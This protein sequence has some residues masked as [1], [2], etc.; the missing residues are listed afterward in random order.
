MFRSVFFNICAFFI[1]FSHNSAF[2]CIFGITFSALLLI[3]LSCFDVI[4][5]NLSVLHYFFTLFCFLAYLD[6]LFRH[7]YRFFSFLWSFDFHFSKFVLFLNFSKLF[8]LFGLFLFTFSKILIIC[9]LFYH[10]LTYILQNV[11]MFHLF[12][13]AFVLGF[14][15]IFWPISLKNVGFFHSFPHLSAFS[16]YLD[17]FFSI[18]NHFCFIL[19]CSH[20]FIPFST[21]MNLP[22]FSAF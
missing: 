3:F 11:S 16:A 2:Y 18:A 10:V 8:S 13:T 4:C 17:L 21:L 12:S 14:F 19:Y 15:I 6:L 22:H 9:Y 20:F 1:L 7:C 5:Q